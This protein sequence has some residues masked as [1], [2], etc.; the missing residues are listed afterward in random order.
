MARW[1]PSDKWKHHLSAHS[2]GVPG[3]HEALRKSQRLSTQ[4]VG[5]IRGVVHCWT[6]RLFASNAPHMC[7]ERSPQLYVY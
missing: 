7:Y 5:Q 1:L 6:G 2:S 4:R 3:G